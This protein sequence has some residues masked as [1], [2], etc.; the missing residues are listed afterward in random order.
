MNVT[1]WMNCGSLYMIFKRINQT[2]WTTFWNLLM[3]QKR[4][5]L[6]VQIPPF[7]FFLKETPILIFKKSISHLFAIVP[8]DLL[9]LVW[10]NCRGI[11]YTSPQ[12]KRHMWKKKE[13]AKRYDL[14]HLSFGTIITQR[15]LFLEKIITL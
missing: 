4:G 10:V 1:K 6:H 12:M 2:K 13:K 5:I 14:Q 8:L 15:N 9:L 7:F 3:Y 11:V